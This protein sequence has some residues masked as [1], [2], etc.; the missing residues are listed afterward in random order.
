MSGTP[1]PAVPSG[2]ALYIAAVQFLFVTTWTIYV[3]YLP[4]L[5]QAAGLPVAWTPWILALDQLVFV[6]ADVAA[7][8]FTDRVQRTLGRIGPWIIGATAVS[9]L[10]FL[11]LP[12]AVQLGDAAPAAA[13]ALVLVWTTTSSALRAPPWVLLGKYAARPAL[14]WL[15]SLTL[16]GLAAAGAAAPFLGVALRNVDPR[17]PFALSSLALLAATAGIVHVERRLARQPPAEA[18]TAPPPQVLDGRHAAWMLGL[19]LLAVAFQAHASLNAMGQYLRFISPHELEW[20]M[21]LFWVGFGAAML[22]AGT[23]CK[24]CGALPVMAGAALLAAAAAAASA[25]A[26]ELQQLVAAQLVAGGAW[27]CMLVAMFSSAADRG[28]SGREG[29]ALGTMFAMLALAAL[30]RIGAVLAGVPK[31]DGLA[32]LLAWVP[33]ALWLAGGA[34][35]GVLAWRSMQARPAAAAA[36]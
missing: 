4:R 9:C 2:T 13:L 24:R 23:L 14:P 5:L 20:F 7:G 11:L 35:I 21:P 30:A 27:G 36:A 12:H 15:N 8:V 18:A 34:V 6:A 10:A 25:N 1:R 17:L 32:P 28:R 33:V 31:N 29:L 16:A 26:Q 22:A 3:I 19:L